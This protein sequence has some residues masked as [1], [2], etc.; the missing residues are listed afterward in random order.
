M[1]TARWSY[2]PPDRLYPA[3]E[4]LE[5]DCRL[6]TESTFIR[7]HTV[8]YAKAMARIIVAALVLV[9][10]AA[11]GTVA[12]Q[13]SLSDSGDHTQNINETFVPG[14][15][16]IVTLADSE[17]PHTFYNSSAAVNVY[18]ENDTLMSEPTDY[19]WIKGN[20]TININATGD[21]SGDSQAN[22]TYGYLTVSEEADQMQTMLAQIPAIIGPGLI[23]MLIIIMGAFIW[24]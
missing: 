14:N 24:Q 23:F 9:I 18:D 4:R 7:Q 16:G 21:L 10:V 2:N 20:G 11:M 5:T 13:S 8:G 15:S 19:E 6:R 17:Q 22:A 3:W 12:I 1:R